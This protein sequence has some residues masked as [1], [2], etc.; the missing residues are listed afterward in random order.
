MLPRDVPLRVRTLMPFPSVLGRIESETAAALL[1]LVC[2]GENQWRPVR[3][4]EVLTVVRGAK[5]ADY[6][7]MTNPFLAPNFNGLVEAGWAEKVPL[8]GEAAPALV[9]TDKFFAALARMA[10]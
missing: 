1:V 10:G 6:P 5:A 9:L 7:W 2:R 3:V 8:D 4:E